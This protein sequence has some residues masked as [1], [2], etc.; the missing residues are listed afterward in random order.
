MYTLPAAGITAASIAVTAPVVALERVTVVPE[1]LAMVVPASM[2]PAALSAI[3]GT[4]P[5]MSAAV[6]VN[7][8]AAEAPTAAVLPMAAVAPKE[9]PQE[10]P[11]D[12]AAEGTGSEV[13]TQTSTT[14]KQ[15]C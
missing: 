7:V 14:F 2:P 8:V 9:T 10:T 12:S 4:S 13:A 15:L 11:N 1:M 6:M 3:P 5:A